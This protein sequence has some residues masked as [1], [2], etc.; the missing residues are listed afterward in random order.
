MAKS[1][2]KEFALSTSDNP[3]NPITHFDQWYA[4]DME[5]GY[6]SCEYLDKIA[7]TSNALSDSFNDEILERAI[8][9]I[10]REN[11]IGIVTQNKINYIKVTN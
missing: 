3:F 10:I 9:A 4:Y 7:H 2:R 5:K 6:H 8:D 11:L 1:A